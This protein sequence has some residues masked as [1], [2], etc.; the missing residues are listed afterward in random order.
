MSRPCSSFLIP[1]EIY[2][3]LFFSSRI[4]FQDVQITQFSLCIGK[5]KMDVELIF[6]RNARDISPLYLRRS[7]RGWRRGRRGADRDPGVR[8]SV[9]SVLG[10]RRPGRR[11][12]ASLASP[13]SLLADVHPWNSLSLSLPLD[14]LATRTP[15]SGS[16]FRVE[17][18]RRIDRRGKPPSSV[19]PHP[20]MLRIPAFIT[21]MPFMRLASN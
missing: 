5:L 12:Q 13:D 2:V 16:S 17:A 4:S 21:Y 15:S 11:L 9:P 14:I 8:G 19:L 10:Q 20:W 18:L 6:S 7:T 1:I 3:T